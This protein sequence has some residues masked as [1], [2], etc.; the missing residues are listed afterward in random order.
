[1]VILSYIHLLN[2]SPPHH[3]FHPQCLHLKVARC[4]LWW[5]MAATTKVLPSMRATP[6][7]GASRSHSG[8]PSGRPHTDQALAEGCR[9][10]QTWLPSGNHYLY[11]HGIFCSDP[12]L[13]VQ[14]VAILTHPKN[15]RSTWYFLCIPIRFPMALRMASVHIFGGVTGDARCTNWVRKTPKWQTCPPF[16]L[17]MYIQVVNNLIGG[18]QLST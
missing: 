9:H 15:S 2:P 10:D 4:T 11:Q 16:P 18:E 13:V 7:G 12:F 6:L 8:V 14:L 17:L 3:H 1:M 5:A